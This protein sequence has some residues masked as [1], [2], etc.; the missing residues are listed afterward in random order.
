MCVCVVVLR[1]LARGCMPGLARQPADRWLRRHPVKTAGE[2]TTCVCCERELARSLRRALCCCCCCCVCAGSRRESADVAGQAV[3]TNHD[4]DD[5]KLEPASDMFLVY[6][7]V[8]AE[9]C[10]LL[11]FLKLFVFSLASRKPAAAPHDD[12]DDDTAAEVN[13]N[14]SS[15]FMGCHR[16]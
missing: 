14:Y 12:V 16:A 2:P 9:K 4:A 3:A 10:G 8:F 5:S 7:R 13:T 6:L 1:K 11:D 15:L